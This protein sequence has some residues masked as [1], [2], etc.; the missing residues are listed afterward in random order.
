MTMNQV[1]P[2]NLIEVQKVDLVH[3][4]E[5]V[6]VLIDKISRAEILLEF[7]YVKL[8][9]LLTEVSEGDLWR[10]FSDENGV[11]YKNFNDY[12]LEVGR[13]CKRGRSQLYNYFTTVRELKP[14]LSE[15]KIAELG[16][17]KAKLL[18][19]ATKQSGALPAETILEQISSPE[20]TIEDT[21]KILAESGNPV[22]N[23]TGVWYAAEGFWVTEEE[24]A[25]L[26][27]ADDAARRTDPVIQNTLPA[28]VQRKEIR[29]RL[30]ME[31]LSSHSN[32]LEG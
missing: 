14:F 32:N 16:I 3:P 7:G 24:R 10:G 4:M 5:Q 25:T 17:S 18:K 29:L 23:N 2:A 31:F 15:E 9:L 28:V 1:I 13:K 8:G 11:P 22:D 12:I 19:A 21:K 6:D 27:D 26:D 20:T 30:A